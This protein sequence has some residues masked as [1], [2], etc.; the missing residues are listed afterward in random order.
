MEFNQESQ[1]WMHDSFGEDKSRHGHKFSSCN[2]L[3][4]LG[5]F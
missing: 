3:W 2:E 5:W 1:G 4:P